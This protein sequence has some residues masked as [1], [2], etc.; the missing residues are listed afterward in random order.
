M[1]GALACAPASFDGRSDGGPGRTRSW[2][3]RPVRPAR[4]GRCTC[5]DVVVPEEHSLT[6]QVLWGAVTWHS[7]TTWVWWVLGT[8]PASLISALRGENPVADAKTAPMRSIRLQYTVSPARP[9]RSVP[10]V[11]VAIGGRGIHGSTRQR[12]G[13]TKW[14]ILRPGG[15]AAPVATWRLACTGGA[16]CGPCRSCS[17]Q[18]PRAHRCPS[19]SIAESPDRRENHLAR[20]WVRWRPWQRGGGLRPAFSY[21]WAL[22]GGDRRSAVSRVE[23]V[24]FIVTRPRSQVLV[25]APAGSS[26]VRREP[27][28]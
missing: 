3:S 16:Q 23:R 5:R 13:F 2:P 18:G 9:G 6:L 27:C 12:G 8:N 7:A 20:Y 22:S 24:G 10:R 17:L 21:A 14:A 1:L 25:V 15:L 11:A 4:C 28:T 26:R 19:A